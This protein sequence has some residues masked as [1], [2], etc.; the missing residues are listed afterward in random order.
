MQAHSEGPRY[1]GVA[2]AFVQIVRNEG[3]L[4]LYKAC[5]QNVSPGA[6]APLLIVEVDFSSSRE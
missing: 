3:F 5:E 2:D 1:R 6:V 4:G